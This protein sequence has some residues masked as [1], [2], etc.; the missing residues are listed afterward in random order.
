MFR[1]SQII[2]GDVNCSFLLTVI[3]NQDSDFDFDDLE[4][5]VTD[6]IQEMKDSGYD[7]IEVFKSA[8]HQN[9]FATIQSLCTT[10]ESLER[11]KVLISFIP[12]FININ[13]IQLTEE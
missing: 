7:F 4:E 6:T 10:M 9:A 13:E 11:V 12:S 5:F 8:D 1:T 3:D 2:V